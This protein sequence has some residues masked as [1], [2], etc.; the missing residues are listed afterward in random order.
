MAAMC[1][2]REGRAVEIELDACCDWP[3]FYFSELYGL[4]LLVEAASARFIMCGGPDGHIRDADGDYIYPRL[5]T[6]GQLPQAFADQQQELAFHTLS[7]S[8]DQAARRAFSA[9]YIHAV[10][11]TGTRNWEPRLCQRAP[12]GRFEYLDRT[13]LAQ[14]VRPWRRSDPAAARHRL[15]CRPHRQNRNTQS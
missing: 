10:S 4:W 6:P 8:K 14:P 3:A 5:R 12:S 7:G 15:A 13:L 11:Y 1:V 2:R 9:P